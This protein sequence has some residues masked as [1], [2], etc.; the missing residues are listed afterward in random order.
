MVTVDDAM[1]FLWSPYGIGQTIFV[2]FL[3][4]FLL[5]FFFFYFLA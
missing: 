1:C 5:S 4:F 3:S 2:L